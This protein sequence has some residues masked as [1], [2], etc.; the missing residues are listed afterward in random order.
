MQG[1]EE[2]VHTQG[3]GKEIDAKYDTTREESGQSESDFRNDNN[4][5]GEM[6]SGS[7]K[8]A[9]QSTNQ[10]LRRSTCQKN[11]V[12]WYGYNEYMAHHYAYMTKVVEVRDPESYAKAGK[13][14]N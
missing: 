3:K 1:T 6:K 10:K 7:A 13:D 4:G 11:H 12:K 9:L 2:T 5:T 8:R 14:V